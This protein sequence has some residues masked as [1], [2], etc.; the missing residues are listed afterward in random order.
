VSARLC[1]RACVLARDQRGYYVGFLSLMID[2]DIIPAD[3]QQTLLQST[4]VR[5]HARTHTQK[6]EQNT[7]NVSE[8]HMYTSIMIDR[9]RFQASKERVRLL[10]RPHSSEEI[11]LK[12]PVLYTTTIPQ[13]EKCTSFRK[14]ESE[15]LK[16]KNQTYSQ[17]GLINK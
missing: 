8:I 12:E 16:K 5:I 15:T 17:I 4:G 14:K 3:G 11:K 1:A 13:T 2:T 9:C 6:V 7:T 10:E